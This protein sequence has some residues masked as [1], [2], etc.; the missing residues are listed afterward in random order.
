MLLFGYF[1]AAKANKIF[2][3]NY[4]FRFS[5]ILLLCS[6]FSLLKYEQ[7][8]YLSVV[9]FISMYLKFECCNSVDRF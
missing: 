9:F 3:I 2:P 6:F 4:G 7:A 5:K 8:I 1:P